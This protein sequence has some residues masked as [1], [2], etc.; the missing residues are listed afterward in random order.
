MVWRLNGE[1]SCGDGIF[2]EVCYVCFEM[3]E[4]APLDGYDYPMAS[5]ESFEFSE[6]IGDADVR[7]VGLANLGPHTVGWRPRVVDRDGEPVEIPDGNLVVLPSVFRHAG[8]HN[9]TADPVADTSLA[10]EADY[11]VGTWSRLDS[12]SCDTDS[13]GPNTPDFSI[14]VT[15]SRLEAAGRLCLY[16]SELLD[17]VIVLDALCELPDGQV[18]RQEI[19]A[20]V[21]GPDEMVWL[22]IGA[23][24]VDKYRRCD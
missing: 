3:R 9:L 23:V 4:G 1:R 15:P 6:R 8:C 7:F 18:A 13:P 5:A 24:Q 10:I 20:T 22:W 21:T 11:L 19:Q 2:A 12:P 17:N 14:R 16:R